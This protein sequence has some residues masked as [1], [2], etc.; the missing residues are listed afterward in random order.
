MTKSLARPSMKFG[1][2][3]L[4]FMMLVPTFLVS[5][6]SASVPREREVTNGEQT[7]AASA[8]PVKGGDLLT[9][10]P[11]GQPVPT[12]GWVSIGAGQHYSGVVPFVHTANPGFWDVHYGASFTTTLIP[13]GPRF[14]QLL[15]FDPTSPREIIG[16]L[17][18]SW[19]VAEDGKSYTFRIH[20]A[21]WHD[22]E[23]VNADDIVFSLDRMA[24]PDV[25]R[26]RVQAIR[27][28]YEHSTAEAMGERTVRM[29]L[30]SPSAT[31]LGWLAV[32]YLKMY[33]R[34]GIEEKAQD[35]LNCC[36]ENTFGSGPWILKEWRKGDSYQFERYNNYFKAPMP[37]FDGIQVFVIEDYARR[38][39]SLKT[40][41][42]MG[43]FAMGDGY[44]AQDM[45]LVQEETGG[46]M[47][48]LQSGAGSIHGLWLNSSRAPLED[49]AV[50][51]AIYL[52]LD[53]QDVIATATEGFGILGSFFPPGYANT[54]EQLLQLPGFQQPKTPDLIEAKDLL[55]AAGLSD[56]FK[57]T[58]NIDQSRRSRTNAELIAVQLR[59]E[60]GIEVELEVSDR[61]K[62]YTNLRD[63][64]H[65]LSFSGTGVFF[66][67]PE[68]IL[69]Q[70]F[71]KDTTR[72]PYNWEH[73][74]INELTELQA[75]ELNSD[76]RRELY[77]KLA[78]IL[79]QGESHYIPLYWSGRGGSLDD[80]LQNFQPP[81]HPHTIWKWEH[82]WFDPEAPLPSG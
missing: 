60:L 21:I 68:N 20:E 7:G 53:R 33:P 6:S 71:F 2:L 22:G 74:K 67:D 46:K 77:R 17:A 64:T 10:T 8:K 52:A 48:A 72:N 1:V 75:R 26:G 81:Y 73:P 28:F 43:A 57:L 27:T 50:R 23:P 9:P 66:K 55:A 49:P 82:V 69:A 25:T 76:A 58:A 34:H 78:S 11:L 65:D 4:T 3:A 61:A 32:D 18:E 30:K 37:F 24:Q 15:M 19:E 59:K 16:D 80:Q 45:L 14:N 79:H 5:C 41:Q 44:L 40:Q 42:V 31:A 70:F 47:R 38:L 35:E 39:A 56:G 62:F 54:E 36:P 51:K 12:I 13:S 29:P 63:G